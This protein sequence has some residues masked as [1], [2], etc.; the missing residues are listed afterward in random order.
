MTETVILEARE[1][2]RSYG[3]LWL[4]LSVLMLGL[5][6]LGRQR[7]TVTN[8]RITVTSG[9]WTKVRDDI[10]IFRIR[11]V[12]VKQSIWHRLTGIGDI[13]IKSMEGRS[14][15][16]HVLRGIADPIGVSEKIRTLWNQTARP[17]GPAATLD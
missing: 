4:V 13:V 12:V 14:E 7:I 1:T 16:T 8:E 11:D 10:E 2:R 6:F 5:P 17:K 3:P 9:F 15:E